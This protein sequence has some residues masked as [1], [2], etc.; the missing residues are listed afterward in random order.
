MSVF[1]YKTRVTIQLEF[2]FRQDKGTIQHQAVCLYSN[3]LILPIL[4]YSYQQHAILSGMCIDLNLSLYF[5]LQMTMGHFA[6][7]VRS[8]TGKIHIML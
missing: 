2:V 5:Y 7:S 4:Q 3:R 6:T 1:F 8:L